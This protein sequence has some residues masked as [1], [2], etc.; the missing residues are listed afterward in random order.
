MSYFI[1]MENTPKNF[2]FKTI[3]NCSQLTQNSFRDRLLEN[4]ILPVM[5]VFSF[6]WNRAALAEP[7]RGVFPS[8]FLIFVIAAPRLLLI[9]LV[10][11]L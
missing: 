9:E 10:I 2:V 8:I 1:L 3:N 4:V 5:E 7:F 6:F 11:S